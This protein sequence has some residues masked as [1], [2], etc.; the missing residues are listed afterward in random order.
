MKIRKFILLK[1]S[2]GIQVVKDDRLEPWRKYQFTV[3]KLRIA[4]ER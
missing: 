1:Q 4:A 2:C 3:W